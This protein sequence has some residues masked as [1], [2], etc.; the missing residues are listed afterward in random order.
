[1]GEAGESEAQSRPQPCGACF[2]VATA[3]SGHAF[4][5][6]HRVGASESEDR[7]E[8]FGLQYGSFGLSG[9]DVLKE[10]EGTTAPGSRKKRKKQRF[11]GRNSREEERW[12]RPFPAQPANTAKRTGQKN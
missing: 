11:R 8:E 12:T 1:M 9:R 10:V 5:A 2:W 7:V 6:L 3:R 4:G